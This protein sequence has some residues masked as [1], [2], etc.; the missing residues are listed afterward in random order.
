MPGF[1]HGQGDEAWL[2]DDGGELVLVGVA[3]DLAHP[4]Q[5][6]DFFRG[7]LRVASGD[8]D[9]GGGIVGRNAADRAAGGLV[10]RGG[11]R[12]S[13]ENNDFRVLGGARASEALLLEL[14][15]YG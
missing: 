1:E 9:P 14:A 4:G 15:F 13:V 6:G 3:D 2:L 12:A 7:A 11:H 8:H 5:G 10:S